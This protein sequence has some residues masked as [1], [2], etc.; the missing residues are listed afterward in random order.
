MTQTSLYMM[1]LMSVGARKV[2]GAECRRLS[3]I[4]TVEELNLTVL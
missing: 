4:R 3:G 1:V 2:N